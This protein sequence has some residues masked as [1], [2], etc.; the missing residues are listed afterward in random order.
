MKARGLA[1]AVRIDGGHVI[2]PPIVTKRMRKAMTISD[3]RKLAPDV[4]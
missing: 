4:C 3:E 2:D 1:P